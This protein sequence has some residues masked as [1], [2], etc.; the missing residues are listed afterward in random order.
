[1]LETNGAGEINGPA[2]GSVRL[3]NNCITKDTTIIAIQD[4]RELKST[5]IQT[6]TIETQ[7]MVNGTSENGIPGLGE[8]SEEDSLE[9]TENQVRFLLLVYGHRSHGH[10]VTGGNCFGT[11]LKSVGRL[12]VKY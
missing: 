4:Q 9:T 7:T 3:N 1:M 12:C 2:S 11:N 5:E 6:C 10:F 8:L